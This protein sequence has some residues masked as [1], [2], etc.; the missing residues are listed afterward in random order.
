VKRTSFP[1]VFFFFCTPL[2]LM[3]IYWWYSSVTANTNLFSYS[4][5]NY[6]KSTEAAGD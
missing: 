2:A 3:F 4:D 1:E 5:G 6:V